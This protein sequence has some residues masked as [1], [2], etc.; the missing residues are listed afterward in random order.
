MYARNKNIFNYITVL[1]IFIF[2]QTLNY[3]RHRLNY[4]FMFNNDGYRISNNGAEQERQ[5]HFGEIEIIRTVTPTVI[6]TGSLHVQLIYRM[7][8]GNQQLK[9][10]NL[11]TTNLKM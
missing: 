5:S 8:L 10:I 2:H 1:I 4:N 9:Q 3:L 7:V 11:Q 6:I